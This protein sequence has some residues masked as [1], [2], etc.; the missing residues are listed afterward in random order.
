ME[1]RGKLPVL[2]TQRRDKRSQRWDRSVCPLHLHWLVGKTLWK[3]AKME[4]EKTLFLFGEVLFLFEVKKKQPLLCKPLNELFPLMP[5]A[6]QSRAAGVRV[7]RTVR[8]SSAG[9]ISDAMRVFN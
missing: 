4:S 1:P 5:H 8:L 7:L 9:T 2:S 3:V 6:M